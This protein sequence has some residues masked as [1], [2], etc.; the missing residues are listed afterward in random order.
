M[1][2]TRFQRADQADSDCTPADGGNKPL[3]AAQIGGNETVTFEIPP[4]TMDGIIHA[5]TMASGDPG[6]GEDLG[7]AS[8]FRMQLD[9]TV[10]DATIT[11]KIQ[12]E[13]LDA[14]CATQGAGAAMGEGDF[15][16]TGLN[17]GTAT[18]DPPVADRY[19]GRVL[20][21]NS[22]GHNG[23]DGTLTLR[24]NNADAFYEIPDAPG[25]ADE[26]AAAR[27]YGPSI[28]RGRQDQ[29]VHPGGMIPPCFEE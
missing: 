16:A 1:A 28:V 24:T 3:L 25:A 13:A 2:R 22:E 7:A 6:G 18:W 26:D 4:Q 17:L 5:F 12:F 29:L 8:L 14:A 27:F 21:T 15:S 20:A 10:I 23:A 19:Q 11:C 9:I